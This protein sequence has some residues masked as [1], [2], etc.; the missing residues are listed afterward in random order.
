MVGQTYR[1]LTYR[2]TGYCRQVELAECSDEGAQALQSA[3]FAD[4]CELIAWD[5]AARVV[6][7]VFNGEM[8]EPGPE[9]A[10]DGAFLVEHAA[11]IR[12][13]VIAAIR[14]SATGFGLELALACDIRIAGSAARF[15]FPG[16]RD[17]RMPAHGGTQRL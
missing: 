12:Q 17:G 11:K 14:G 1:T 15:G 9:A 13:P 8:A 2:E 7:L 3:E 16:I 4:V 5:E 6:V 10:A